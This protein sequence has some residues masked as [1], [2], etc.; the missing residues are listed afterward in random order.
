MKLKINYNMGAESDT[1]DSYLIDLWQTDF[2]KHPNQWLQCHQAGNL[3]EGLLHS[4]LYHG[5]CIKIAATQ[6]AFS[7]IW[8]LSAPTITIWCICADIRYDFS[9]ESSSWVSFV[10]W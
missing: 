2:Q 9:L 8:S 4:K 3:H 6:I 5:I 7:S 10:M 1:G